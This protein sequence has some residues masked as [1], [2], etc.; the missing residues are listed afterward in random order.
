M[1]ILIFRIDIHVNGKRQD[2]YKFRAIHPYEFYLYELQ[3]YIKIKTSEWLN[4]HL[5]NHQYVRKYDGSI[6]IECIDRLKENKI[7]SV[8]LLMFEK[9]WNLR[10]INPV[11][12]KVGQHCNFLKMLLSYFKR[13]SHS[14]KL[15][16]I[17]KAL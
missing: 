1:Q 11:S 8:S 3:F 4:N 17:Y 6:K 10:K 12:T 15:E 5:R 13:T 7:Y 16:I 9:I 14:S 2:T